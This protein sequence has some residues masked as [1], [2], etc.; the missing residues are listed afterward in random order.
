MDNLITTPLLS[1][2]AE[3]IIASVKASITFEPPRGEV[4]AEAPR[5]LDVQFFNDLGRPSYSKQ[6]QIAEFWEERLSHLIAFQ[7]RLRQNARWRDV[8]SR[9][10]DRTDELTRDLFSRYDPRRNVF[11]KLAAYLSEEEMRTTL[12]SEIDRQT[13]KET[14]VLVERARK[15]GGVLSGFPLL[16][17]GTG[18]QGADAALV[19]QAFT[20]GPTLAIDI[21]QR[22]GGVFRTMTPLKGPDI[23]A[24]EPNSRDNRRQIANVRALA[25]GRQHL[26]PFTD[27]AA[28]QTVAF[29]H[30]SYSG[31]H[32]FA[33][34]IAVNSY[35]A[36]P[37]LQGARLIGV[38]E[39]PKKQ[40]EEEALL[41]RVQVG[42]TGITIPTFGIEL[43]TGLGAFTVPN[44]QNDADIA[45]R[46][47]SSRAQLAQ[48]LA[49]ESN[50]LPKIV[51]GQEFL[52]MAVTRKADFFRAL[53]DKVVV[54]TGKKDTSLIVL[55]ALLGDAPDARIYGDFVTQEGSP[56]AIYWVGPEA[57]DRNALKEE[58]QVRPR[59]SRILVDYPRSPDDG[60]A[61]L[62]P[63]SGR[64]T[65]FGDE[66][67][68]LQGTF[69]VQIRR[70]DGTPD[71]VQDADMLICCTGQIN[72]QTTELL[73]PLTHFAPLR[74]VQDEEGAPLFR[75]ISAYEG[76]VVLVGPAA[77]LRVSESE[78]AF[79]PALERV[80]ENSVAIWLNAIKVEIASRELGLRYNRAT[81]DLDEVEDIPF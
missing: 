4:R 59:Y 41:A 60:Y 54:V 40:S 34:A 29:N 12:L 28:I 17:A 39:N 80:R 69:D 68:V 6:A 27:E 15:K 70:A 2:E 62:I 33:A 77:A 38:W 75:E 44:P 16:I 32:I 72:D 7:R 78:R 3:G 36:G 11:T 56:A 8:E 53:I 52:Q 47:I 81:R 74:T 35:L 22:R 20:D 48:Y 71:S 66:P 63:V 24:F 61:A 23:P 55:A 25:G 45:R 10:R 18:W 26:N 19:L 37:S 49:G 43:A 64:V 21:N 13:A 1:Q 50:R 67:G 57:R 31:N 51:T 5:I 30:R 42:Q 46:I 76:R 65:R 79:A 14:V 9:F 58:L 73:F